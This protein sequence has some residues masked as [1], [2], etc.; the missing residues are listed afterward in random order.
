MFSKQDR[1]LFN[2]DGTLEGAIDR[3]GWVKNAEGEKMFRLEQATGDLYNKDG[4]KIGNKNQMGDSL[5]FLF[6][7]QECAKECET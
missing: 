6:D 2:S 1:L 7:M 3:G 5:V 4:E